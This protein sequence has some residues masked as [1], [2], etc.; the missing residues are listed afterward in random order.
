MANGKRV[1]ITGGAQGIGLAT[2]ELFLERGYEVAIWALHE[3]SVNKAVSALNGRVFGQAV[4]VGN[5]ERVRQAYAE[6][7]SSFGPLSILVNN[8]G[9]TLTSR[10]L[11]EESSYWRRVVD[12]NLWGVIYTTHAVL[13]DMVAAET[14][15]IVNVVSDAGRVG[16][17][18]EAVYAAS[19][20]GVVAF[21]KSIAQ[22][23]ARHHIRV[24]CVSPGPT[25]TRILEMNSEAEDA[26]KL[27][28]KMIRRIPLRQIAEPRDVAEAVV[29]LASDAAAQITGQVLSVSGGLTMV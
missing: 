8:A 18:G 26:Q 21:S 7:T 12:T 25:R 11:D 17:A 29:F 14:G 28:D 6:L 4:D 19:K 24:N 3:D 27:I 2:A 1:L 23:V 9:Y 10:F 22:E 20:G 5:E 15:S 16:M 13:R